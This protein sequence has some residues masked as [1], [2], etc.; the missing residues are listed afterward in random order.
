MLYEQRKALQ[1]ILQCRTPVM[2][3]RSYRCV[4]CSKERFAWHSCNHRLCP[5]CGGEATG[6][7][8]SEKLENRLPVDHFMVTFTLPAQLR[9]LC[10][11]HAKPFL[12]LF[13]ASSAQAIKDVLKE[14][15]HLGGEVG[16]MGFLQTWTQD[17]RLHPHIHYVVPAIGIDANGKLKR[18]RRKGW[19]ARGEVFASRLRTLLLKA[20]KA[21]G[22]LGPSE[23]QELWKIGWN[24][25]VEN[26]LFSLRSLRCRRFTPR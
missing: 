1:S 14:P 6:K 7:W 26:L 12:K 24:C 21:E 4:H 13:F 22:L 18:P 20:I 11:Y 9:K 10:R 3:G 15:R 17:L 2:G 23:L 25:D 8:V 16:F 19:L 5:R